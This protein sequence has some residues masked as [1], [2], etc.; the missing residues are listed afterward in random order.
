MSDASLQCG[1]LCQIGIWPG[2]LNSKLSDR[3]G[4]GCCDIWLARSAGLCEN[5]TEKSDNWVMTWSYPAH[6]LASHHPAP[7]S[8]A[9]QLFTVTFAAQSPWW[10][11]LCDH[12]P[13]ALEL[14]RGEVTGSQWS[15]PA[16][17]SLETGQGSH[18]FSLAQA[19][20]RRNTRTEG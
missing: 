1:T 11:C 20:Q 8:S 13:L 18:S 15:A 9:R 16:H 14:R 10:W 3:Q 19:R 6:K 12:W 7:G 4:R 17:H 5:V 2:H